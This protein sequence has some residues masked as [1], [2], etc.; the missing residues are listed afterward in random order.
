MSGDMAAGGGAAPAAPSGNGVSN[1][2]AAPASS[3]A[4]QAPGGEGAN[5]TAAPDKGATTQTQQTQVEKLLKKLRIGGQDQEIDVAS[6]EF[7]REYQTLK[8]NAY[9]QAKFQQEQAE[10]QRTKER[11]AAGDPSVFSEMGLD[12]ESAIKGAA[13]AQAAQQQMSPEQ[14]AFAKREQELAAR[15]KAFEAQE[16]HRK[17][18]QEHHRKQ[19]VKKQTFEELMSAAKAAGMSLETKAE[20]GAAFAL[21]A[22]IHAAELKAGRPRMTPEQLGALAERVTFNDLASKVKALSANPAIRARRS[23]ELR[24][25]IEAATA[26]LDGD[27]LLDFHGPEYLKRV[28][29]AGKQRLAS[30]N[31]V[32][33]TPVPQS[34]ETTRTDG[35]LMNMS[36]IRKR[37]G[38]GG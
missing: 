1:G 29:A 22:R 14:Q 3:T 33:G 31:P 7:L 8:H 38:F 11:L 34:G 36:D 37:Y 16:Q 17:Q 2:T 18:V 19:E 24:A 26:G 4:T 15:E 13:E 6:P 28:Y 23:A 9:K 25:L 20:R 5:G 10:F 30:R 27:A 35:P 21:V 12:I 32:T